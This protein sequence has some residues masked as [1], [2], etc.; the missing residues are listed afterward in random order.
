MIVASS[1]RKFVA[2]KI[3]E[4]KMYMVL[5]YTAICS[6]MLFYPFLNEQK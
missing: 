1:L 5:W 4:D 6:A 3:L 2:T